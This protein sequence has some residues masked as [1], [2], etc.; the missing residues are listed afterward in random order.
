MNCEPDWTKMVGGLSAP[1]FVAL[2]ALVVAAWAGYSAYRSAPEAKRANFQAMYQ[3]RRAVFDAFL[4]LSMHMQERGQA[5]I[6]EMVGRFYRHHHTA[7]FCFDKSL[8][9]EVE[10]YF[11]AAWK[12]ADFSSV[13]PGLPKLPPEEKARHDF[14][15]AT[16][17]PLLEKLKR[18]VPVE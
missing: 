5:P 12:L 4:V 17:Q 15:K 8:S 14:V 10:E 11:D 6:K 9:K 13:N 1:D 7:S 16:S 18:A 3:E 2:G